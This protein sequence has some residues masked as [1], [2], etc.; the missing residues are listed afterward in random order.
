MQT[1]MIFG[2]GEQLR[3]AGINQSL[4]HAD[5]EHEDWGDRAIGFL[6][7]YPEPEFMTEDLRQYAYLNGLPSPPHERAWGGVIVR[8]KGMG[9]ITHMRYKTVNNP[10]AHKT[11]ASLWGKI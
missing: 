3:D 11:P 5:Q 7:R 2:T 10:L 6:I 4:A 1:E 9:L 8:A